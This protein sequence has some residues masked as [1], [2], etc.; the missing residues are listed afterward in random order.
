MIHVGRLNRV[1]NQKFLIDVLEKI[2]DLKK[3]HLYIIGDGELKDELIS[4]ADVKGVSKMMT[5]LPGNTTPALYQL[6]DCSLLPSFS[7]AFGMVA[8]E[9][10]LMGVPCFVSTN[11]PEDVDIGM[12]EFLD[13]TC[14]VE[15]WIKHILGYDYS[16]CRINDA[17]KKKFEVEELVT[18]MSDLY[19]NK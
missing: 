13:L 8:V 17:L 4:Y 3:S 18:K 11:V 1:K 16:N 19:G 2:Q 6:M 10:Q 9:S 12:C 7:E 14:G 15:Y 5:I